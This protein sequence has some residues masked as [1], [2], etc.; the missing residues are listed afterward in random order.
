[1]N[2]LFRRGGFTLV[3]LM[4]VV[5]IIAIIAAIAIPN[6]IRTRMTA[7]ETQALGS[8]HAIA[9]AESQFQA[10]AFVDADGDGHGDFGTLAQL[11][12]PDGAGATTPFLDSVL[13]AGT[14]GGY[15]FV[16]T[17]T[18]GSA[19][20]APA[21]T[22]VATPVSPGQS[23]YRRFFVDESGVARFTNDGTAPT[24]ASPPVG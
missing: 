20:A 15:N 4:I 9:N 23:G 18:M 10:A 16:I 12:N 8:I 11:A 5:A 17:V 19:A 24:A 7:G 1:M 2:Q 14:K 3:E 13:G 21:Y 6:F 22:C